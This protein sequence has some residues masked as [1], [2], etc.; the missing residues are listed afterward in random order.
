MLRQSEH[1]RTRGVTGGHS[2]L[3]VRVGPSTR[4]HSGIARRDITAEIRTDVWRLNVLLVY[5]E[6]KDSPPFNYLNNITNIDFHLCI[7]NQIISPF[8]PLV[9]T[10][11]AFRF[12]SLS[13]WRWKQNNNILFLILF[14]QRKRRRDVK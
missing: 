11:K 4:Q 8:T 13:A 9:L 1:S 3:L 2:T 6:S 14:T 10:S 7:E 5:P 12:V